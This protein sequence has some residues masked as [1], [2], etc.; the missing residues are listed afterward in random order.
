[1][2][3]FIF[4]LRINCTVNLTMFTFICRFMVMPKSV[5]KYMTSIGQN[6]G[7]LNMSKKV[8]A[9]APIVDIVTACQNLNSGNRLIN[10]LNSSLDF[11]GNSGPSESIIYK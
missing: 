2:L 10:G 9:V 7:I 1:M 3:F 11:V 4:L 5:M 8:N 6:T